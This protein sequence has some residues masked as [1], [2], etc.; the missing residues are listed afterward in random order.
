MPCCCMTSDHMKYHWKTT[1]PG[2]DFPQPLSVHA[3]SRSSWKGQLPREWREGCP[4]DDREAKTCPIAFIAK[5]DLNWRMTEDG[6]EWSPNYLNWFIYLFNSSVTLGWHWDFGDGRALFDVTLMWPCCFHY[7]W[8]KVGELG[9][10]AFAVGDEDNVV[11]LRKHVRKEKLAIRRAG[12]L[13]LLR[14]F[15]QKKGQPLMV[16]R[17]VL[18]LN[19]ALGGSKD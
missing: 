7:L 16:L 9:E 3:T 12:G 5:G 8:G 6:F 10:E 14:E 2:P 11:K 15:F 4:A 13:L 17:L 1:T 19:N 18:E